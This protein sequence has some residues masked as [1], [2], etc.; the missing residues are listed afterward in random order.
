MNQRTSASPNEVEDYYCSLQ[1]GSIAACVKSALEGKDPISH[2]AK[3]V[4]G[5][6]C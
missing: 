4:F 3:E 2:F 1:A 6:D 5:I